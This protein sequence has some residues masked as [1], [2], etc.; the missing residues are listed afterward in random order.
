MIRL[1][2]PRRAWADL[3]WGERDELPEDL[4]GLMSDLERLPGV[5]LN[6]GHLRVPKNVW[7]TDL[8]AR[9]HDVLFDLVDLNATR[10]DANYKA[11][12]EPKRPLLDHQL[13][14]VQMLVENRGGLL[15]DEMGLAKTS[16]AIV[17]AE[18]IAHLEGDDRPRVIIAPKYTRAVWLRELLATGA[19]ETEVDFEWAEGFDTFEGKQWRWDAKWWFV[20]Y[21]LA[22]K[23]ANRLVVNPRGKPVVAIIDEIHWIKN[24]RAQRS[25]A[26]NALAG[27]A[28]ARIGLTGTPISNKPSELWWPL[29]V[30]DGKNSWGGPVDFRQRYCSAYHDGHGWVDG[31]PSC[32]VEL[33][34]RLAGGYLRRLTREVVDLPPMRRQTLLVDM[35]DAAKEKHEVICAEL[36]ADRVLNAILYGQMGEDTLKAINQLRALTSDIKLRTT[37]RHCL[38][39]LEADQSVVVFTWRRKTAEK[40]GKMLQKDWWSHADKGCCE[41]VHGGFKQEQRD[42]YV[43]YFQEYGGVLVATMDSLKEGVTLTRANH[44]VLHDLN[45]VPSDIL[46]AEARVYRIGQGQP[47]MSYWVMA[48]HSIDVM[49]ARCLLMKA[50]QIADTLGITAAKDAAAELGLDKIAAIP[51]VEEEMSRLID[52][53]MEAQAS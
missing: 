50:D 1:S 38:D 35:D 12:F 7:G 20:H 37:I 52:E 49:I 46:Q 51:S 22:M 4:V 23:W 21:Q 47:V 16:S 14:A 10:Y 28:T 45:W 25:K 19:I 29:S 40:I 43:E 24:G 8:W 36:G 6:E 34:E 5:E 11:P 26:T 30:I 39:I 41:V 48:E 32:T 18:R 53:W 42:H 13:D 15:A 31:E 33:N 2:Y 27:V 3:S 17:A 44:V 9:T